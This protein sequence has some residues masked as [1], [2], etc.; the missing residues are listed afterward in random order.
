MSTLNA[1]PNADAYDNVDIRHFNYTNFNYT[2]FNY[3]N[4]DV[5]MIIHPK[6]DLDAYVTN[7]GVDTNVDVNVD[8]NVYAKVDDNVEAKHQ[9]Q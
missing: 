7:I 2:N 5:Y 4:I 3:T 8:V 6:V 9:C 1:T